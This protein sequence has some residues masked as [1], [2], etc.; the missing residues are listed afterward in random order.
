MTKDE[1]F[2]IAKELD[3]VV[4]KSDKTMPFSYLDETD[5]CNILV[6]KWHDEMRPI[7]AIKTTSRK[8]RETINGLQIGSIIGKKLHNNYYIA[9]FVGSHIKAFS[10]MGD[11]DVIRFL[12]ACFDKI[13]V[14]QKMDVEACPV[15]K[16]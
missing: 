16:L 7:L 11:E 5:T 8:M 14:T 13:D 9:G 3:T 10:I 12:L 6:A 4:E 2:E 15:I 1:L